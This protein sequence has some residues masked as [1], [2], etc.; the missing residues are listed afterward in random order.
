VLDWQEIATKVVL[1]VGG[2]AAAWV[3]KMRRD[4]NAA[5]AKIRKLEARCGRLET[6]MDLEDSVVGSDHGDCA[7]GFSAGSRLDR[8]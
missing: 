6:D 8:E 2:W 7:A 3:L 4:V 5:H 1:A